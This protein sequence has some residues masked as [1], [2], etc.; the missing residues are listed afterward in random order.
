[1]KRCFLVV[2]LIFPVWLFGD[3]SLIKY[4][5]PDKTFSLKM[6]GRIM[7]D[8]AFFSADREVETVAGEL[9][10]GTEFRRARLY[11]SG[12]L[13]QRVGFKAQYDFASG[14]AVFKDVYLDFKRIMG[15][16]SLKVGHFKEPFS[17]EELTSSKYITFMERAM[18][19]EAFAPSRNTGFFMHHATNRFT[20]GLGAFKDADSQGKGGDTWAFTTRLAGTPLYQHEGK[21]LLHLGIAFS[22]RDPLDHKVRVRTRPE[23]HLF[24]TRLVDTHTINSDGYQIAGVEAAGVQGP[25]S[26][27]GEFIQGKVDLLEGTSVT[28]QGYYLFV[29]FFLTGEHRPYKKGAFSRVK[30]HQN[31]GQGPG[32]WEIALRYS[33]IDLTDELVKGG[34]EE[35][36]T[37]GVNWYLNPYMRI[38]AN[39]I[40]GD[41]IDL[42]KFH[43]LMMRFQ[44]DF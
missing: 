39:Y 15:K 43:T 4:T 2:G 27:Q 40:Y 17:L 12:T 5:S 28:F 35:N 26:L 10:E 22:L 33:T 11:I 16:A 20:W 25:F 32:A 38:M 34:E 44:V 1:M 23:A 14:E 30:P 29:S 6:G 8:W 37:L 19:V 13:Y 36:L 42:G 31:L 3:P 24:P 7:N 9:K 18:L 21:V 41:I